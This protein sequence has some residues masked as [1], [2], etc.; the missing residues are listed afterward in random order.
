MM[1]LVLDGLENCVNVYIDDTAVS[2]DSWSSH[3]KDLEATLSAFQRAGM[4]IK[5]KK[6]TFASPEVEFVSHV[7]GS[8]CIKVI[9]SKV[10]AINKM[11]EPTN[12]K[13]LKS[14]LS[15]WSY[16][17]S[18]TPNLSSI[19][20]PLTEM[21][22]T[23][24]PKT[25][26]LNDSQRQSFLLLKDRLCSSEVLHTPQYDRDFIIAA[27]ASDY[28][29]GACLAQL[30]DKGNEVPIAYAFSKLT[31]TQR[32]WST[33]EKESYAV[34]FALE[35][36]STIIYGCHI[37]LYSDHNPLQYLMNS[38]PKSSKLVRWVMGLARYDLEVRHRPGIQNGNADC[39]SRLLLH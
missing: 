10:D 38:A 2:S 1:N 39:L 5:L 33:V 30:N 26:T 16:Y 12:K 23:S 27:D 6:C 32:R 8:C 28:A 11:S 7:I 31:D 24:Y 35:K 19:A 25:F 29:V 4:T 37:I 9:Q 18:F 22:K 20:L 36:F 17:R 34:V 15:M 21:T 14:F 13:Q 3:L